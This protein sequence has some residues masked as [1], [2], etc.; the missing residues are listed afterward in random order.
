[1]NN[2][3]QSIISNQFLNRLVILLFIYT[4]CTIQAAL[5]QSQSTAPK[6]SRVRIF[7]NDKQIKNLEDKGIVTNVGVN[8]NGEFVDADTEQKNIESI[9]KLGYNLEIIVEDMTEYYV[10]QANLERVAKGKKTKKSSTHSG[11][12]K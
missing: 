10:A 4:V 8:K 3:K 6:F 7:C 1:M 9:K 12:K 11:S 2:N 5:A